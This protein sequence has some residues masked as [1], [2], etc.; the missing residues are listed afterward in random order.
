MIYKRFYIG[1]IVQVV[2]LSLTPILFLYVSA[3]E[4]MVVTTYSLVVVWISQIAYL[5][6]YIN[7]TNRDLARFFDAFQYQDSTLVFN[8]KKGDIAFRKLHQS[9][10]QIINAFGKVRIEKEKDMLK[11][12]IVGM[13]LSMII[14]A[15][16]LFTIASTKLAN[17]RSVVPR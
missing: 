16:F 1:I 11:L 17:A 10:N 2:L 6:H 3:K 12:T 5:L 13:G 8:E 14:L 7:K 15:G 9:F 4:Y